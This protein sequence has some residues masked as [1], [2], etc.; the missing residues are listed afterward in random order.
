MIGSLVFEMSVMNIVLG[1][2]NQ[3]LNAGLNVLLQHHSCSRF[4]GGN[5]SNSGVLLYQ[6]IAGV[7]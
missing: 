1:V 6:S 2:Y 4:S 5:N 3:S 7:K